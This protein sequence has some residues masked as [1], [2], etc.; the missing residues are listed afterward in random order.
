MKYMFALAMAL[1]LNAA[2]NLLMKMGMKV[3]QESG[4]IMQNGLVAATKTVLSSSALVCGLICFGVNAVFYMYALQSPALKISIAYP[5]MVGGGFA[6]IAIIA[7]Y[8]PALSER[9]TS[10]QMIGVGLILVG[11]VLV[12]ARGAAPA[13]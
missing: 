1:C 11:I 5:I 10:G 9:L 8:H 7:R 4:G 12:A 13:A 2:A 3:V 6:I